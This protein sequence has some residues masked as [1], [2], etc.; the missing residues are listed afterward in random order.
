MPRFQQEFADAPA[1]PPPYRSEA[2][3]EDLLDYE[4]SLPEPEAHW[5]SPYALPMALLLIAASAWLGR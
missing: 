1:A 2:F 5:L 3:A 4:R